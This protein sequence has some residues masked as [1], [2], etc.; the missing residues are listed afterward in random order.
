MNPINILSQIC[1]SEPFFSYNIWG[2]VF[3]Y[4]VEPRPQRPRLWRFSSQGLRN[5]LS[6]SAGLLMGWPRRANEYSL[7]AKSGAGMH[8]SLAAS[9]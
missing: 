3:V 8:N 2:R 4:L 6:K 7:K 5:L 9:K 1:S